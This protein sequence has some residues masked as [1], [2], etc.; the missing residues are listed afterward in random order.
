M[1]SR[2]KQLLTFFIGWPFSLI[3]LYFIFK[4][5]L[6]KFDQIKNNIQSINIGLLV[7]GIGC[8]LLY[9]FIR[10]I[11]WNRLLHVMGYSLPYST[12]A[13]LWASSEFKR[14]IPGN[15]WSFVG[16]S[17]VFTQ[18][19]I[20]K[21]DIGKAMVF[22][23]EF[24]LLGCIF[25]SLLSIPFLKSHFS[26]FLDSIPFLPFLTLF[27]V[28]LAGGL[29]IYLPYI[30]EKL[31]SKLSR[32]VHHIL[33]K[34]APL[35]TLLLLIYSSA[36]FF[37]F[38]LGYYFSLAS[39]VSL[40]INDFFTLSGFFVFSLLVGLLSF[41]TPTGL[42]VREGVMTVGLGKVLPIELAGFVSIA[43]RI[44]LVLSEVI[45]L[46]FTSIAARIP[47][48]RM[49]AYEKKIKKNNYEIL[50]AV[51]IAI[52]SLYLVVI[53]FLRYDNFYTGRFDLG[54]M[55][56]TVWNTKHGRIFELTDPNG[57]E[58]VSRLAFHADFILILLA[59][60]YF[61]WED[62][63]MLLLIQAIVVSFG[64]FFVYRLSN[65]VLHNKTIGITLAFAYLIN[66][67]VQRATMYDF[68]A[69]TFATTF[70]LGSFYFLYKKSYKWFLL[71][72]FLAAITKEQIWI[73]IGFLGIYIVLSEFLKTKRR[74][75]KDFLYNRN[76]Q[77]G[78]LTAIISFAS[79]FLL[80]WYAIPAAASSQHFALSYFKGEHEGISGLL[81]SLV[82]SP[83]DTI[84][85]ITQ[86]SRV[87]YLKQL[88]SPLGY[89][90]LIAPG[91][92][93][94]PIADFLLNLLSDKPELHQIYYQY[95]AAISPFLFIAAIFG[96]KN[97]KKI[98][99]QIPTAGIIF[100]I[101]FASI[102]GAYNYGP[103]PGAKN[104]N[105]DM[106]TKPIMY[107]NSINTFL[108]KLGPNIKV[109]AS[110]SIGSHLSHRLYVYTLPNGLDTAD[111]VIFFLKDNQNQPSQDWHSQKAME[112]RT[113]PDYRLIFE[114]D[115]FIGFQR[116]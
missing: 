96:I 44:F 39:L 3:A 37:F 9:Y 32:I 79:F 12:V 4:T 72:S 87:D 116:K 78:F 81:T 92:L 61:I 109:A 100:F 40:P 28:G 83:Q 107:R 105:L 88:F 93:V 102:Q 63:R 26:S 17:V 113:R 115:G 15:I 58:T 55:A 7:F 43:G 18:R 2:I 76:I 91:Y 54:N 16:R 65:V 52:S 67:S 82:F 20:S 77:V 31:P 48:K 70:L 114:K 89:L 74:D 80:F 5:F 23:Q 36:A 14:Y 73:I 29:Y 10:S 90:P 21:K 53:C 57:T 42:G 101:L 66:P 110:N 97:L 49:L 64:A 71:L 34:F 112:L 41:L 69:V 106:I 38:G 94:F 104:P 13:F 98:V 27:A 84:E 45:F 62:P 35:E 85:K 95:T 108:D 103:L 59:P 46:I 1:K 99:P 68:H 51:L 50:L 56:Q 111:V 22:E 6:P 47:E 75:I 25:V 86:T 60:F 11:V 8:F 19:G 24:I 30:T 33:P